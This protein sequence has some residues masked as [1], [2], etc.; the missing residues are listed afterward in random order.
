M[1]CT[2]GGTQDEYVLWR[3]LP[4]GLPVKTMH[5]VVRVRHECKPWGLIH[6]MWVSPPREIVLPS[7]ETK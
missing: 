3:Y 7:K 5:Y 1:C 2:F 4:P 6:W